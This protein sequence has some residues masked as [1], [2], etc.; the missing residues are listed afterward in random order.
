MVMR[1]VDR[2]GHVDFSTGV[3]SREIRQ[4]QWS[5]LNIPL[6]WAATG[7]RSNVVLQWLAASA[8]NT[9][10]PV[11]GTSLPGNEAVMA[12]WDSLHGAMQVLGIRS[13]G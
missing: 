6:M 3:I 8:Q 4:Q 5:F 9:S 11:R 13:K 2:V 1:L 10:V 7:D 12:G